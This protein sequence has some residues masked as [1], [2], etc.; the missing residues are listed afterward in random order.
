MKEHTI[1]HKI[2]SNVG[3]ILAGVFYLASILTVIFRFDS[4]SGVINDDIVLTVAH[5][6]L[7]D[8]FR[9][10]MEKALKKFCE[11]KK[12]QGINVKVVQ[13]TVPFRGYRQWFMTQL[14][15]DEP[16]DLIVPLGSPGLVNQYFNALDEYMDQPNP[17]NKG[18]PLA[19]VVWRD[20]FITPCMPDETYGKTFQPGY[21]MHVQ[22]LFVNVDL[23]KKTT[24]SD[25]LP[26]DLHEFLAIC[27][28][29]TE[30]NRIHKSD[31]IPIGVRG[32]DKQTLKNL[33]NYYYQ[34]INTGLNDNLPDDGRFM[35]SQ[36]DQLR[37]IR[38]GKISR[39]RLLAAVDCIK[40]LGQYFCK[41]F[42]STSHEQ[43]Q[44]MF[45]TGKVLF[46]MDGSWN[47]YSLK[48]NNDFDIKIIPIPTMGRNYKYSQYY[49]GA[50]DELGTA[51]VNGWF[52]IP[53]S[54]RHFKLSLELLQYLTSWKI[55][56]EIMDSC[57]WPPGVKFARYEG[58]LKAMKPVSGTGR[59][60]IMSPFEF[61]GKSS[62][63]ML[64]TLED[65]IIRDSKNPQKDFW[66][67]F[68]DE[69]APVMI[70]QLEEASVNREREL[71]TNEATRC[72]I[73]AG[74]LAGIKNS[75]A[76]EQLNFFITLDVIS[77]TDVGDFIK[78]LKMLNS[79][80]GK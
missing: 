46:V 68:Q 19:N 24:G 15:G 11:L 50:T 10:G 6:Q 45:T 16:A 30:Y 36:I 12:Q 74:K 18:T 59:H 80:G 14:L 17:F 56:Q 64:E 78:E 51:K 53:K 77:A 44:Y 28:K 1:F 48:R 63:K 33:F 2:K 25:V 20:S 75:P 4:S 41:G 76:R 79:Q 42:L 55:N 60:S 40:E 65:I 72:S 8:G 31:Y 49:V 5:W 34:E 54:T 73:M 22:R 61:G 23:L 58:L 7:E 52:A 38:Q 27:R 39:K 32:I 13:S 57:K 26:R 43:T 3:L 66:Q 71:I 70:D 29:V 37:G 69:I 62:R 35:A 67:A 9:E 47:A 21:S